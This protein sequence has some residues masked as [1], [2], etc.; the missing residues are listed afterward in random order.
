MRLPEG[1]PLEVSLEF[2]AACTLAVG[3]LG[4]ADRNII[5][6]QKRSFVESGLVLHA[7][8]P[9]V[10]DQVLYPKEP[11]TF[12]G[13]HGV[14]ADSLPDAWGRELLRRRA[15]AEGVEFNALGALDRLALIGLSGPGALTYR[16]P[17]LASEAHEID[18]D[19][20]AENALAIIEGRESSVLDDLVRLGG[21]SGGARPK[22]SVAMDDSGNLRPLGPTL[23]SGFDAWI[24]KFRAPPDPRDAG[25]LEAAYADMARAAGLEVAE[26][27]LL[28][29]KVGP[30]YFA[31]KRFDR[32]SGCRLHMVSS[33]AILE[34]GWTTPGDY[35]TLL[36]LTRRV[37]RDQRSV[38]AVFRRAVFNFIAHNRDDHWK[39]HAFLMDAGG[40]WSV[41]PSFDLTFSPGPS[42]EH[43]LTIGGRAK[44]AEFAN[45]AKAAAAESIGPRR[46]R[47][48][49]EEVDA[50]VARY[51][52]FGKK[53][54]VAKSSSRAIVKA[55]IPK[56][57][58]L[59]SK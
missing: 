56:T 11:R 15:E 3:R 53:Y 39:Q 23:P 48:I 55:L 29:S 57:G 2:G 14:F 10:A 4:I 50:A 38:E 43:Y 40:A 37:T 45:F 31:T 28:P 54:D 27:K 49:V 9:Q 19:V 8:F 17:F 47:D 22:I 25:P 52:E 44:D 34:I 12:E 46:A 30:G 1:K 5:F 13:L 35:E 18:L 36:K 21:S 51:P 7:L 41:A 32:V 20:L 58:R 24:V 42:G 6:E 16:P 59:I 33:S 26:T